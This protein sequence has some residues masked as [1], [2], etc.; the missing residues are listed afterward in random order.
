MLA[1]YRKTP[2][3]QIQAAAESRREAAEDG[4]RAAE[5]L[6]RRLER[7]LSWRGQ[8][9]DFTKAVKESLHNPGAFEHVETSRIGPDSDGMNFEMVFRAENGFGALRTGRVRAKV[10]SANCELENVGQLYVD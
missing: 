9:S 5:E 10:N 8:I 6:N 3:G 4:D 7:C 1:A 2:E